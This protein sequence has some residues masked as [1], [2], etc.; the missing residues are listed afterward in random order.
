MDVPSH[1]TSPLTPVAQIGCWR[2][3]LLSMS[4]QITRNH[5]QNALTATRM[6]S[7]PQTPDPVDPDA[8]GRS[9]IPEAR[10][11]SIALPLTHTHTRL[12]LARL[13]HLHPHGGLRSTSQLNERNR[14]VRKCGSLRPSD[15]C[16]AVCVFESFRQVTT[17]SSGQLCVILS[18]QAVNLMDREVQMILCSFEWMRSP[19]STRTDQTIMERMVSVTQSILIRSRIVNSSSMKKSAEYFPFKMFQAVELNHIEEFHCKSLRRDLDT[20]AFMYGETRK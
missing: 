2:Y 10:S 1:F 17:G 16:C 13:A 15:P 4:S 20:K 8:K 12:G 11:H 3:I 9:Q 19:T 7:S 5:Y 6:D 14:I 18:L